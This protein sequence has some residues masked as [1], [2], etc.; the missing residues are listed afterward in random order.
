MT[1][2]LLTTNQIINSNQKSELIVPMNNSLKYKLFI[3]S[4]NR[5]MDEYPDSAKFSIPL[6][7]EINNVSDI[8]LS[9]INIKKK[10]TIFNKYNIFEWEYIDDRVDI[11]I[12]KIN[13]VENIDA[14]FNLNKVLYGYTKPFETKECSILFNFK[15]EN[16]IHIALFG[17]ELGNPYDLLKV[18]QINKTPSQQGGA[19]IRLSFRSI[20]GDLV[21]NYTLNSIEEF[22]NYHDHKM[23]KMY[24]LNVTPG[25]SYKKPFNNYFEKSGHILMYIYHP[26]HAEIS[27]YIP[28]KY[29]SEGYLINYD[30]LLKNPT[31]HND[32]IFGIKCNLID[33]SG[34]LKK[35]YSSLDFSVDELLTIDIPKNNSFSV[36]ITDIKALEECKTKIENTRIIFNAQRYIWRFTYKENI[37][38]EHFKVVNVTLT[39]KS[40]R[41]YIN[42]NELKKYDILYTGTAYNTL[43]MDEDNNL[44]YYVNMH[45]D[46]TPQTATLYILS[47]CIIT[48]NTK[49]LFNSL[50]I[51]Y[52]KN[53]SNWNNFNLSKKTPINKLFVYG[54][55]KYIVIEVDAINNL[56][57]GDKVVIRGADIENKGILH[58]SIPKFIS[59]LSKK[60]DKYL[61][62]I[63]LGTFF[64]GNDETAEFYEYGVG[65]YISKIIDPAPLLYD[66]EIYLN[67]KSCNYIDVLNSSLPNKVFAIINK[68]NNIIGGRFK[69]ETFIKNLEKIDIDLLKSNNCNCLDIEH[70]SMILEI[71]KVK[72]VSN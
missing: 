55:N 70:V 9:D 6:P 61:L 53:G 52:T 60:K 17:D 69:T 5:D 33:I 46:K 22:N 14:Y 13:N 10:T 47:E 32:D 56:N 54:V 72:K 7:I 30:T 49:K 24:I 12:E 62:T 51:H 27:R 20:T 21:Y 48:E 43:Y 18:I 67:L 26:I 8:T 11:P 37:V 2:D 41:A 29:K 16:L 31:I 68:N 3:S 58:D 66:G 28:L 63:D 39:Y 23:K 25:G 65:G 19:L 57:I 64:V 36:F 38:L 35:K 44:F 50:K 40:N 59:K 34:D 45:S 15:S 71:T 42:N 1:E 4:D